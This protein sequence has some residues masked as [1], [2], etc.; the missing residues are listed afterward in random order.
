MY[1]E[2]IELIEKKLGSLLNREDKLSCA[3]KYSLLNAG[4]RIR[5]SLMLEFCNICGGNI[6]HALPY[7]CALEMIHTY[8]L[9]HD[10]L[11]CMDD[12]DMR[13]G[14]AANHIK[15]GEDIALLAGDALLNTAFEIASDEENA[16]NVGLEKAMKA[17]NVL[18]TCSGINGMIKG[19]MS[20]LEHNN[21]NGVCYEEI[22]DTYKNKT[23]KLLTAACKIG[24]ILADADDEKI[25]LAEKYALNLGLAFQIADDI[26]DV[27]SSSEVLGKPV[28]SD[29]KKQKYTLLS[30]MG[31]DECKSEVQRY[32]DL[33]LNALEKF[34]KNTESLQS[35]TLNLVSR[36]K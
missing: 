13:R 10:D 29:D 9:I 14:K 22:I 26:L 24:C 23:A 8:S 34:N 19:Q 17:L 27:T 30:L 21:V 4:K 7:A 2:Y 1:K 25:E 18:A 20:D 3:M 31:L 32:T 36:K 33:A 16:K 12:D 5:P 11:P 15:F 35:F 6:Q 28:G